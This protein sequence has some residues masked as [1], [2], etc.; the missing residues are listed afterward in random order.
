MSHRGV[1]T[2]IPGI[3][4]PEQAEKNTK[5]LLKIAEDD[6]KVLYQLFEEKFNSLVDKMV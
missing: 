6:L 2:V 5:R 4:T 1:S 3:K